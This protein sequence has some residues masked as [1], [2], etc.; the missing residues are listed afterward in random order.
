MG[1]ALWEKYW[2]KYWVRQLALVVGYLTIY[3]MIIHFSTAS[4]PITAPLR[5]TCLLFLPYRYWPLLAGVDSISGAP[6]AFDCMD[7]LGTLWALLLFFP[8][9]TP[10]MPIVWWCREKLNLFPGTQLV[11]FRALLL[12]TLL[13]SL[14]WAVVNILHLACSYSDGHWFVITPVIIPLMFLGKY[15][16]MIAILPWVLIV[17]A[18]YLSEDP[19]KQ[20]MTRFAREF[21]KADT[22]VLMVVAGLFVYWLSQHS[23]N[24]AQR[25]SY[26][27]VFLPIAWLTLRPGWR[28]AALG[29]TPAII[30]VVSLLQSK[31]YEATVES[32]AFVAFVV[33][34]LFIVGARITAQ[35]LK[36][37]RDRFEIEQALQLAR[38]S[39]QL[40][41]T[42][43]RRTAQAL[44]IA[45]SS[46][47]LTQHQLLD[48]MQDVLPESE[49]RRYYHQAASMR[50]HVDR[51]VDSL[52]PSAW[53][54][55]GLSAALH[56]TIADA[57]R[58]AAINYRCRIR[59]SL[60]DL[61]PGMHAAIYRLAC[62]SVMHINAQV[63]CSSIQLGIRSGVTENGHWVALRVEGKLEDSC[64][65]DAVFDTTERDM[66]G[67]RLG[68]YGLGLV[69]LRNHARLFG[70]ELR[71]KATENGLRL[72][73]ML[74][75]A[76][77][78]P[79]EQL[80][81]PQPWTA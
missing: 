68:A 3:R 38:Q 39:F 55:R 8:L 11:N 7:Q 21:F 37:E 58:E 44:Q 77:N 24:D 79:M 1:Q 56:E 26:L 47:Q 51:L 52:Y 40:N 15:I 17:R 35:R 41:E 20:R 36:E 34:C 78:R 9:C 76:I 73:Y 22:I 18:E 64:I 81:S 67:S 57:L 45:G 70:G 54:Q 74:V 61:A 69:A 80:T 59:G 4:W 28:S 27:A 5:F 63:A 48:R 30:C 25:L 10:A 32:E 53:R 71:S 65:N 12:C 42:R 23:Y 33:T 19:W 6:M 46:L 62:E 29:G 16:S 50:S 43:I 72:T 2:G 49:V 14:V 31:Q 75:D 13:V 66:L 60:D